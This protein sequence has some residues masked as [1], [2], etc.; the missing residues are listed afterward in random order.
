[1]IGRQLAREPPPLRGIVHIA[2]GE[3]ERYGYPGI[4]RG[5][6]PVLFWCEFHLPVPPHCSSR[7]HGQ[8][9]YHIHGELC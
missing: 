3:R 1:M 5:H 6:A 2:R 9:V 4:R 8:Q 7:K